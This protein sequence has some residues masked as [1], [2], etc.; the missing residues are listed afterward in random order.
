MIR[1]VVFNQKG[2]V[3]KSTITCNL[4][5]MSAAQGKPTL[6]VDLD[7]QCN[8]SCYLLGSKAPVVDKT[9]LDYYED[10]LYSFLQY[11]NIGECI[12]PTRFP[13]LDILPAHHDLRV[14]EPKLE[15]RHK[16][17]KLKAA[18]DTLDRYDII[19]IDTPPAYNFYTRSAL[20]AGDTCLIP[21]DCDEFSRRSLYIV[22]DAIR[23]I[24]NNHNPNLSVEGIVVNQFQS[25]AKLP[26]KIVS[27]LREEGLPLLGS[28]LSSSIKIRESRLHALPMIHFAPRHKLTQEFQALH[29]ELCD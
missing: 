23:E 11:M 19:Y 18:L 6:V 5:A 7:P 17:F 12:H 9:L 26:L 16:L 22:L 3:G 29:Q 25:R 14:I 1:R 27:E 21:F 15:S 13:G 24:K 2:G 28:Y 20:I 8:T 10:I 4:A